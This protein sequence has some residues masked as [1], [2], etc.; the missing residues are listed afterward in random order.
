M[1]RVS[2][3]EADHG[4]LVPPRT[5]R[6]VV[7]RAVDL[8]IRFHSRRIRP[9][10]Y[11][12]I[13]VPVIYNRDSPGSEMAGMALWPESDEFGPALERLAPSPELL[14]LVSDG[15]FVVSAK[16]VND[17]LSIYPGSDAAI[18]DLADTMNHEMIHLSLKAGH[19]EDGGLC[20]RL[21]LV[22]SRSVLRHLG[23]LHKHG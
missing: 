1:T 10:R 22:F 17:I 23:L 6:T 20:D 3:Q 4:G 12:F 8:V 2:I 19:D 18:A 15:F 21:S 5:V 14:S 13:T 11:V 9:G 16:W 7:E